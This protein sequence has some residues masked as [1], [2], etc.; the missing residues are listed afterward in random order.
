MMV[1]KNV[2]FPLNKCTYKALNP[3]SISPQSLQITFLIAVP[4]HKDFI[5]SGPLIPCIA[6][7]FVKGDFPHSFSPVEKNGWVQIN[8]LIFS[9][10]CGSSGILHCDCSI[11]ITRFS[12]TTEVGTWLS[13]LLH[14][15]Y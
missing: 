1:G 9:E 3:A 15:A 12:D 13:G 5:H 6:F 4:S 14:N 7:F 2:L 11:S 8:A 10:E